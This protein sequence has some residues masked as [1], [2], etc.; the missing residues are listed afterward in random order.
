MLLF[1][2]ATM[3]RI[4]LSLLFYVQVADLQFSSRAVWWVSRISDM[5]R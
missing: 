2:F 3:A 1:A 4:L 5:E